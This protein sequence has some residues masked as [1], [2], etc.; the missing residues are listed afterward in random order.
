MTASQVDMTGVAKRVVVSL[1]S[2]I[3]PRADY[4]QRALAALSA[5]PGTAFVRASSVL[6]TEPVDVPAEFSA[7]KFLNQVAI[8]ETTLDPFEFSRRMHA[9]EDDLGRVRTVRNGP[10]TIDIDLIDFGGMVIDTPE[11]VLPHPRAHFRDF[12]QTPLREL[13][14]L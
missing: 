8:F 12:V 14:V 13:G 5:L 3:E 6:E 4:L 9:I 10:R 2:N 11:L 7:L 1:G